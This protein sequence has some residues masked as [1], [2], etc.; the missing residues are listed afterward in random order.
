[1]D[2][3]PLLQALSTNKLVPAN[4]FIGIIEFGTEAFYATK[5]V[6]FSASKFGMDLQAKSAPHKKSFA[7]AQQSPVSALIVS[8]A[9]WSFLALIW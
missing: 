2:F 8:A 4:A 9:L 5:N 3:N 1:L 7:L 6:T